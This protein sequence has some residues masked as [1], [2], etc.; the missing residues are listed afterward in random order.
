MK[1]INCGK[2]T[3]ICPVRLSPIEI[4]K[5]L[6]NKKVIKKLNPKKCIRC[7]LCSYICPSR[8]NLR[9]IVDSVKDV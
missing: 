5:N 8:I 7:G 2:C 4:K 9:E 3:N 6:S 1:C